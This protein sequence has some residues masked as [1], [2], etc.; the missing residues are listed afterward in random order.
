MTHH[1]HPRRVQVY[2]CSWNV[3]VWRACNLASFQPCLTRLR[4]AS[5]RT[6]T[7]PSYQQYDNPTWSHTALLS[8]FHACCRSPFRLHNRRSQLLGGSPVESLQ[9]HI[10]LTMSHWS[11]GLPVCF[12]PQETWVQNPWG[13]LCETG[14]LL[15]ALSCYTHTF[16]CTHVCVPLCVCVVVAF[17]SLS[18]YVSCPPVHIHI[19]VRFHGQCP[20]PV[21]MSM[22]LSMS[23][24]Q[25]H[26]H[27]DGHGHG[28]NLSIFFSWFLNAN[29]L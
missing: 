11:S 6:V 10:I 27:K 26:G 19:R 28:S 23:L 20:H 24:E 7:R 12:P 15:L 9:S 1:V 5:S 25:G 22:S 14:I 17:L 2:I 13:G 16:K 18:M 3:H 4:R 8:R 29:Y 21:S